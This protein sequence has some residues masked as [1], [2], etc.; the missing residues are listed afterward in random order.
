MASWGPGLTGIKFG[1]DSAERGVGRKINGPDRADTNLGAAVS[2]EHGTIL[3]KCNLQAEPSRGNCCCG[4]GNA[5][6]DHNEV[7]RAD[8]FGQGPKTK[9][10]LAKCGENLTVVRR[11]E[12]NVGSEQNGIAPALE[13]CQV[14][15][16]PKRY[17][18][19]FSQSL[20]FPPCCQCSL[21][22]P[23]SVPNVAFPAASRL[24]PA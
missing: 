10:L 1:H 11:A 7:E 3:N 6:A 9:N 15:K 13:T 16:S 23:S 17:P 12:S 2:A 5:A 18:Y 4:T 20:I 8:I 21:C 22:S 19:P 24:P 14:M